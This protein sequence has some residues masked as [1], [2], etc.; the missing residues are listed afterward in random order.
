MGLGRPQGRPCSRRYQYVTR[1]SL[2]P[3]RCR[4]DRKSMRH[5]RCYRSTAADR[6]SLA[7]VERAPFAGTPPRST[8]KLRSGS[9]APQCTATAPPPAG[10]PRPRAGVRPSAPRTPSCSSAAGTSPPAPRGAR[11]RCSTAPTS[12]RGVA[13]QRGEQSSC[14]CD[15]PRPR[16]RPEGSEAPTRGAGRGLPS[17]SPGRRDGSRRRPPSPG[18][19][20]VP[21]ESGAHPPAPRVAPRSCRCPWDLSA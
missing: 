6:K 4:L 20:G 21:L 10:A 14:G 1:R 7:P 5:S 11:F 16:W 8:C 19:S 18:S 9:C 3:H 15:G 17:P 12:P 2:C 13:R